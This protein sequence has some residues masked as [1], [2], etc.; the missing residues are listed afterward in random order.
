M[1]TL[2]NSFHQGVVPT[3]TEWVSFPMIID[4]VTTTPTKGTIVVDSARWRRVGDSME[5]HYDYRQTGAGSAGSGT[6]LFKM[7][8]GYSI[9]TTKIT[10]RGPS[11]F[12][13]GVVGSGSTSTNPTS[14][15]ATKNAHVA[16]FDAN[17]LVLVSQG[18]ASNHTVVDNDTDQLSN[19]N[20]AYSFD[21][22]VP[23]V[24]G[25]L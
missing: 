6:Y 1:S 2:L 25:M 13:I 4:A 18:G 7:P 5:I 24:V 15:V 23:I 8:T 12:V 10:A 16:V 19:T 20:V 14:D 22:T 3:V 17:S 11:L 21:A 9:D